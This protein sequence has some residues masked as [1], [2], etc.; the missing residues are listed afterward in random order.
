LNLVP[1]KDL[2]AKLA[3]SSSALVDSAQK[4]LEHASTAT[5]QLLY[6][7]AR[8][9]RNFTVLI[10]LGAAFAYGLGS[11]LPSAIAQRTKADEK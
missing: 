9:A 6:R 4:R 11:A 7:P 3:S 1:L 8:A 5:K 2:G 10:V